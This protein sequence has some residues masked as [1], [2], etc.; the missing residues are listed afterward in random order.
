MC[1]L[2]Y[3]E[4]HVHF[5][6]S[7]CNGYMV[8]MSIPAG[9]IVRLYVPGLCA[10][11]YVSTMNILKDSG[12]SLGHTG[13][14]PTT[15]RSCSNTKKVTMVWGPIRIQFEMNPLYRPK[16]PSVRTVLTRQSKELV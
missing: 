16:G 6:T 1:I 8:T 11:V 2:K 9:V 5:K 3:L 13:A 4:L 10:R 14:I 12:M 7:V 15:R